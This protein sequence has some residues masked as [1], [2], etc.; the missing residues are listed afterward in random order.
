MTLPAGAW[1]FDSPLAD[2]SYCV[3]DGRLDDPYPVADP[4]AFA[5]ELY[6]RRGVAGFRDLIG[7]WSLVLWDAGSRSL[8]LASDYAGVRPLYFKRD[9][10][11]VRWS[12][13]LA[14]L[15]TAGAELDDRYVAALLTPRPVRGVTPYRGIDPVPAGCAVRIGVDSV[16]VQRFW[17]IPVAEDSAGAYE[18]RLL[19]LFRVAV[20][21]RTRGHALVCCELSGGLDSSSIACMALRLRPNVTTIS[22]THEGATDAP[23]I[24]AVEEANGIE[25]IHLDVHDFPFV[26]AAMTGGAIP[27]WWEPRFRGL[28]RQLESLGATAL[29]TG[30]MG[31]L[32]MASVLDDAEQVA[33]PLRRRQWGEAAREAYA[34]SQSLRIPI[35]PILWRAARMAWSSWAPADA[36]DLSPVAW[37]PVL[38]ENSL[39][40]RLRAAAEFTPAAPALDW[41]AAPPDR[42]RRFRG[43][44]SWL[45]ARRLQV[46]EPLSHIDYCHPFADRRLVEFMLA[47]PPGEVVRPGVPRRLMRRAFAELLPDP[48]LRRETKASFG[49]FYDECLAPLAHEMLRAPGKL[50]SVEM[51]YLDRDSLLDRLSRYIAGTDSNAD[52][53]RVAILFEFWLRTRS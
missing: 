23:Y 47:I 15:A 19:E 44:A 36:A 26:T 35:Y 45:E 11:R 13:S 12:S 28:A 48:V 6:Q 50:R 20:D 29:L 2:G 22:Y 33:G 51:G 8:I 32:T 10:G 24:R 18:E 43:L 38:R 52:Q 46:P 30:Q 16:R 49:R 39:S 53:L 41:R 17:N 1:E 21:A 3:W 27:G 37:R 31:D 4:A 25:G 9:S 40:P 42:R 14:D 7:D 5:L 34:W